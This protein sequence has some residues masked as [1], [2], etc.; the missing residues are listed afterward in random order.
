[1]FFLSL[2]ILLFGMEG[3]QPALSTSC[4]DAFW[5]QFRS[6]GER[7]SLTSVTQC[8]L[9]LCFLEDRLKQ[10]TTEMVTLRNA[11]SSTGSLAKEASKINRILNRL[12]VYF[13]TATANLTNIRQETLLTVSSF[14]PD[15]QSDGKNESEV[16]PILVQTRLQD[17]IV[18]LNHMRFTQEKLIDIFQENLNEISYRRLSPSLSDE[19]CQDLSLFWALLCKKF[20]N[21]W[22]LNSSLQHCDKL[23][24]ALCIIIGKH[25][26][27]EW[28]PDSF[29]GCHVPQRQKKIG[30]SQE[31]DAKGVVVK[32]E[33]VAN[34]YAKL[35]MLVSWI[36][37]SRVYPSLKDI[38]FKTPRAIGETS[39][40]VVQHSCSLVN[41]F[42]R[43]EE[44][45][46]P[47]FSLLTNFN[48][49]VVASPNFPEK[50]GK[51]LVSANYKLSV[52]AQMAKKTQGGIFIEFFSCNLSSEQ[53]ENM[54]AALQNF[55]TT[56]ALGLK[57]AQVVDSGL[58]GEFPVDD[59]TCKIPDGRFSTNLLSQFLSSEKVPIARVR[60]I[61]WGCIGEV[62]GELNQK[63]SL[64][65]LW[66]PTKSKKVEIE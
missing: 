42:T 22:I 60:H 53:Q 28:G 4:E 58:D 2:P 38:N 18:Y 36:V 43:I 59:F 48:R 10:L 52:S 65:Y 13:Q 55:D 1:M 12:S 45:R 3:C 15:R 56:K 7:L 17:T 44:M 47:I 57:S 54:I 29:L 34:V 8:D 27:M 49:V 46:I 21:D 11:G 35:A 40:P 5:N 9:L 62:L 20:G 51:M 33:C 14:F 64:G 66:D 63:E 30:F 39:I 16:L 32:Q 6:R 41:L 23:C 25:F 24:V 19:G 37:K 26:L 61:F 31:L 50:P